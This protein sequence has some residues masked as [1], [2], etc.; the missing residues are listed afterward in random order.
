MPANLQGDWLH[1]IGEYSSV[2]YNGGLLWL[3]VIFALFVVFFC[4]LGDKCMPG[5]VQLLC[6]SLPWQAGFVRRHYYYF[7][8][9]G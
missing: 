5:G 8:L 3:C 7:V 9:T 1:V 2:F 6:K 4:I